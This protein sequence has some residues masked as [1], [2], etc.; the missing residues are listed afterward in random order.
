MIA[1]KSNI[2]IKAPKGNSYMARK[3]TEA[4]CLSVSCPSSS[5]GSINELFRTCTSNVGHRT[6]WYG[7]VRKVTRSEDRIPLLYIQY[8]YC[9]FRLAI[10]QSTQITST[11]QLVWP[12]YGTCMVRGTVN[13]PGYRCV[14]RTPSTMCSDSTYSGVR[15]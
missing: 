9:S 1:G 11:V 7:M 15:T 10:K 2:T 6:N 12:R 13:F 5:F 3:E 14:L 8:R 4:D